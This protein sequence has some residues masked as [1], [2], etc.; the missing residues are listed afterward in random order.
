MPVAA[1]GNE[2]TDGIA[3]HSGGHAMHVEF[4][5]NG[6]LTALE[7]LQL[8]LL[9]AGAGKKQGF[10]RGD[11][12]AIETIGKARPGGCI[13]ELWPDARARRGAFLETGGF[14]M[15]HRPGAADAAAKQVNIFLGWFLPAGHGNQRYIFPVSV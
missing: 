13:V 15:I 4:V 10:V 1:L 6:Y 3:C 2:V 7:P 12:A 5:T 14:V 9:Q 11:R 8:A